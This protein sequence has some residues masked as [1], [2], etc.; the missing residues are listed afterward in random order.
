MAMVSPCPRCGDMRAE[1]LHRS[2]FYG[3]IKR[4]GYRYSEC[5][6][7]GRRRLLVRREKDKHQNKQEGKSRAASS[8]RPVTQ[9]AARND[10]TPPAVN[11]TEKIAATPAMA[12]AP[13]AP[14]AVMETVT[15]EE[16]ANA[17]AKVHR[18]RFTCQFCGSG[19]CRVSRRRFWER[20]AGKPKML[21]CRECRK[22]F[23]RPADP[24]SAA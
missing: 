19:D 15:P 1:P 7:C 21:R 24:D 11:P 23:P 8:S 5:A 22:R 12:A 9:S 10:L 2:I 17:A 4:F 6:R 14:I 3:L 16:E 18:R 20:L 13:S